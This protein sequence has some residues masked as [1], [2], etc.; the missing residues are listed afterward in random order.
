[1]VI[2]QADKCNKTVILDQKKYDNNIQAM[3]DNILTYK[4]L[5]KGLCFGTE[6]VHKTAFNKQGSISDRLCE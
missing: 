6:D 1:M 4:V 3:L 5:K 2:V